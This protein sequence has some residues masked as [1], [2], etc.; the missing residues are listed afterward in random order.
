MNDRQQGIQDRD[1]FDGWD[2]RF[3]SETP[4]NNTN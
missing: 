1:L 4:D 2:G 3:E